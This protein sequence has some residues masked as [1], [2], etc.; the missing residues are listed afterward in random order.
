[1]KRFLFL[2]LVGGIIFKF[3]GLAS[4]LVLTPLIAFF[5]CAFFDGD[6]ND[7]RG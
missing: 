2:V 5:T 6:M 3:L 7:V 4:F 1:M